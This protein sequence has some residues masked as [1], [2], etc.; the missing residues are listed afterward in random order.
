M[1]SDWSECSVTCEDGIEFRNRTCEGTAYGG[2][3]CS[4][5]PEETRVCSLDYCPSKYK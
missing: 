3:Y 2:N 1:W 4:G 5:P